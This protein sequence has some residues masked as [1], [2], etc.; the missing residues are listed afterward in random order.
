MLIKCCQIKQ[1]SRL[2]GKVEPYCANKTYNLVV[3]ATQNNVLHRFNRMCKTHS[4]VTKPHQDTPCY[5]YCMV[6][7]CSVFINNIC[8]R[9]SRKQT[10]RR[11][12]CI[13]NYSMVAMQSSSGFTTQF[14]PL[15]FYKI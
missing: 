12:A 1:S 7:K 3:L 11:V 6:H 13:C 10:R 8:W 15:Q 4:G 9:C 2:C 5:I 14:S